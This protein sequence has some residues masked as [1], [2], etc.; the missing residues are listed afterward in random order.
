MKKNS[1]KEEKKPEREESWL[2]RVCKHLLVLLA[3]H[4][5][6]CY[7]REAKAYTSTEDLFSLTLLFVK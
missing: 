7:L 3:Q 6:L 1:Q 2:L 4:P 5:L